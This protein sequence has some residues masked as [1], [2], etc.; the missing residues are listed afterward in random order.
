[1]V[2]WESHF[3]NIS[4]WVGRVRRSTSAIQKVQDQL[5]QTSHPVLENKNESPKPNQKP[6][7]TNK[8]KKIPKKTALFLSLELRLIPLLKSDTTNQMQK[9]QHETRTET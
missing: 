9:V 2:G 6:R 1:M 3:Y 5:G 7:K 8:Q 4:T